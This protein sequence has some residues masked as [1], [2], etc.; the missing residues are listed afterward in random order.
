MIALKIIGGLAA[1][2]V[3]GSLV[4]RHL[5]RQRHLATYGRIIERPERNELDIAPALR[6]KPR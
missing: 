2:F 3:I 4:G 6:R 5:R 1:L